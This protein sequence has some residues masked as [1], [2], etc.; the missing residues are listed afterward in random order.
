V[1]G[2]SLLNL[3][4]DRNTRVI[5]FATNLQLAPGETAS[6]V[7]VNLVDGNNQ[8]YDVPAE[9]VRLPTGFGFTQVIFRLPNG[10]PVGTCTIRVK[11]HGQV[12]NAGTMRI[13]L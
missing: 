6:S 13:R 8:S 7:I 2:S 9:E 4:T 10:L 11:A 12:S 3:G 5:I 1:N